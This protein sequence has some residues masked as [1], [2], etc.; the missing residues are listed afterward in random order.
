MQEQAVKPED[1]PPPLEVRLSG[2]NKTLKIS[3][4]PFAD[5]KALYQALL[6]EL[7][8]I[9]LNESVDH[10]SLFKD[11]ACV[12]FSSPKVEAC[13][14]KCM[15]RCTIE[16]HRI[17]EDTFEPVAMRGDYI[18]VLMAVGRANVFPFLSSLY[19]EFK[20]YLKMVES[21]QA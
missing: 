16:G 5:A 3:L 12:A 13:V 2:T 15:A 4:A 19:A 17:T 8:G 11:L 1:T 10:T 7:K 6:A 18:Q 20:T 9:P 14:W 21:V